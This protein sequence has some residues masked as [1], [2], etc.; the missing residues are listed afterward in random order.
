[1]KKVIII[2]ASVVIVLTIIIVLFNKH[3]HDVEK[4][5]AETFNI[6]IDNCSLTEERDTH[7]GFLGDGET[8]YK[9]E[10][11]KFDVP[12]DWKKLP[13]SEPLEEVMNLIQCDGAGCKDFYSKFRVDVIENGYYYFLDRHAESTDKHDETMINN[14]A[15]YNFSLLMYDENLKYLYYYKLDT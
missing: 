9:L 6:N 12:E 7:G 5:V 11:S 3:L 10:C 15:S 1:M 14:R 2:I 4:S 8:L 13:L